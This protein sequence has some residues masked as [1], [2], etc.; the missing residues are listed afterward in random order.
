MATDLRNQLENCSSTIHSYASVRLDPV[1]L[2]VIVA[3]LRLGR[4][5]EIESLYLEATTRLSFEFPPTLKEWDE[6]RHKLQ[7]IKWHPGLTFDIINL[8]HEHGLPHILPAAFYDACLSL[9]FFRE[10]FRGVRRKDGTLAILSSEDQKICIQ[11]WAMLIHEQTA[12]TFGWLRTEGDVFCSTSAGCLEAKTTLY[13]AKF[14]GVPEMVALN[15]WDKD[16]EEDLCERC[17]M[18]AKTSQRVGRSK[19]WNLLPSFFGLPGWE[20]LLK[21]D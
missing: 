14:S 11:G 4:K 3:F 20:E 10:T 12:S 18:G 2:N 7:L 17:A 15:D 9:D 5:Y 16:Y 13:F 8:A 21:S 6:T 19:V 1:S